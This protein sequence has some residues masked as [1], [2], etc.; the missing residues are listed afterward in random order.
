MI[1]IKFACHRVSWV[2]FRLDIAHVRNFIADRRFSIQS[3][4]VVF[5]R[6]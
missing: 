3:L 2:S 4:R 6:Q 1:T 5:A